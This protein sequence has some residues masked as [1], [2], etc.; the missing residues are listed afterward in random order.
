MSLGR[1]TLARLHKIINARVLLVYSS[2]TLTFDV[3]LVLSQKSLPCNGLF[4]RSIIFARIISNFFR[5]DSIQYHLASF[6]VLPNNSWRYDLLQRLF[7]QI[8]HGLQAC[9]SRVSKPGRAFLRQLIEAPGVCLQESVHPV[10]AGGSQFLVCLKLDSSSLEMPN[11]V[12]RDA[13]GPLLVYQVA[14]GLL[15][16]FV[17][18]MVDMGIRGVR[19]CSTKQ[20]K[21]YF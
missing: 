10:G 14:F 3:S 2:H 12:A 19:V 8:I 11:P 15:F 1:F 4:L 21:A 5:F 7:R 6:L 9:L 16:Q 18:Q 20:R 13:Q 17:L